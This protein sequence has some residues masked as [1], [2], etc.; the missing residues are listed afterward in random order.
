M[1]MRG[2]YAPV[3][4]ELL[5]NKET[6]ELIDKALQDYPMYKSKNE[7]VYTLIPTREKLNQKL[8]DHYKYREIG[9]ETVGR[10][11]DELRIAMNEIMPYYYQLYK[12]ADVLNGVDDPFGN[13]DIVESYEEITTGK[14]TGTSKSESNSN[15]ESNSESNM[16]DKSKSVHSATPQTNLTITSAD[17][18]TIPYADDVNWNDNTSTSNGKNTDKANST[19]NGESKSATEGTTKHTLSRKGNQGVST[20]A[21]DLNELRE[22]FKNIEQMIINDDRI[23][24]LFMLVY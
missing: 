10:F 4:V 19:A 15:A 2:R 20:Y 5:E 9:F 14:A 7:E 22:T 6:K 16:N 11:I 1:K 21:H 8:L 24:E 18:D 13:V 12:S 3:L 17:I 23:V